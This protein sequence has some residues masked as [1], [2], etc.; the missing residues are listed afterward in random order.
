M[1]STKLAGVTCLPVHHSPRY[2]PPC[3]A[4]Q[5]AECGT[6]PNF[7]CLSTQHRI[8]RKPPAEGCLS[9]SPM[10]QPWPALLHGT[11]GKLLSPPWTLLH[12]PLSQVSH[13]SKVQGNTI[14]FKRASL[15]KD[16]YNS[17]DAKKPTLSKKRNNQVQP[18][19]DIIS[20]PPGWQKA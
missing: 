15:R 14:T 12:S 18:Q 2:L 20:H 10:W 4:P 11:S 7:C 5:D 17:Q 13:D 1:Y 3:P 9:L 16:H 19:G 8:N 6:Q